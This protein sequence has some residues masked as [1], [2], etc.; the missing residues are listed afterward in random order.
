MLTCTV[1]LWAVVTSPND[2]N[3]LNRGFLER[4]RKGFFL[5]LLRASRR[6]FLPGHKH[7]YKRNRH[8]RSSYQDRL[9]CTRVDFYTSEMQ[10]WEREYSEEPESYKYSYEIV[11]PLQKGEKSKF[12]Y[13]F[14]FAADT[15]GSISSYVC[16]DGARGTYSALTKVAFSLSKPRPTNGTA[17]LLLLVSHCSTIYYLE[18]P[19]NITVSS[20]KQNLNL[21]IFTVGEGSKNSYTQTDLHRVCCEADARRWYCF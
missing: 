4:Y 11:V 13:F 5:F 14:S 8:D 17:L 12:D 19:N 21:L 3:I 9:K 6:P 20:V 1:I 2:Y 7:E 16:R 18:I 15:F 10:E